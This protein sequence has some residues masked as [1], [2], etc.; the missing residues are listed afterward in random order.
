MYEAVRA[1]PGGESTVARLAATA[2]AQG[3]E[4]VVVRNARDAVVPPTFDGRDAYAAAIAEAYDADVVWGVEV[5]APRGDLRGA[6]RRVRAEYTLVAVRGGG[7]ARN[8]VA[9]ETPEVDVLT[10]PMRGEGDVNHVLARAAAENGV[11]LEFDLSRVLR[12]TGGRRVRALR[13][14]RKLRELAADADAPRVA[15]AAPDSHLHL[16]APRE[17][18]A[19]GAEVG[20]EADAIREGL[21]EWERLATRNR[22]RASEGFIGPG[23]RRGKYDG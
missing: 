13:G 17:L 8:R 19:V 6:I 21:R 3:F 1:D 22:E 15:S 12:A 23:V 18:A 14:L 20:F 11:R 16:R 4:G 9:V 5:T 10:A 2:A 7:P